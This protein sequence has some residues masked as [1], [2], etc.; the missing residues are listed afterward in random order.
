MTSSAMGVTLPAATAAFA[1][2]GHQRVGIRSQPLP[3][4]S[5]SRKASHEMA[6][7]LSAAR[8]HPTEFGGLGRPMQLRE[9]AKAPFRRS[10][11]DREKRLRPSDQD[12]GNQETPG[13]RADLGWEPA[14][15]RQSSQVERTPMSKSILVPL[16]WRALGILLAF[17]AILPEGVRTSAHAR[18][19]TV[20]SPGLGDGAL[21]SPRNAA[22]AGDCGGENVSPALAWSDA[23]EAAK[24]Y[25]VVLF[26]PD[27]GK[28]FRELI[29]RMTLTLGPGSAESP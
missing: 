25:A 27:G 15:E 1:C 12:H 19:F 29:D 5:M 26:D 28:G 18:S 22:S 10:G 24:S 6:M 23:P 7:L 13:L 9:R 3:T 20:M 4:T 17:P 16:S 11:H 8:L 2:P 14:A 21:P